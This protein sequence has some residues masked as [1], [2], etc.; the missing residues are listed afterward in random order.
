[1]TSVLS[2]KNE[3]GEFYQCLGVWA[4]QCCPSGPNTVCSC[5]SNVNSFYHLPQCWSCC[6]SFLKA[7]DKSSEILQ[8]ISSSS[9]LSPSYEVNQLQQSR[10]H[11]LSVLCPTIHRHNNST[12]SA[13]APRLN[14]LAPT[15][16]PTSVMV[17]SERELCQECWYLLQALAAG[18]LLNP[19]N[20]FRFFKLEPPG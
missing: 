9:D 2:E 16:A 12:M 7:Q 10:A 8:A 11:L 19:A 17:L 1:M 18:S 20:R 15:R 5:L 13:A 6:L 14:S 4:L 3:P